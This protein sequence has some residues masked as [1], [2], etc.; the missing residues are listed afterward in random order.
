M[1]PYW[2]GY[3]KLALVCSRCAIKFARRVGARSPWPL[4]AA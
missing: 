3:L 4:E 1:R 2:K